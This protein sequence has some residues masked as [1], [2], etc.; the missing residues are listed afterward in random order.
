MDNS[1][2]IL[3][4]SSSEKRNFIVQTQNK[5]Y[6]RVLAMDRQKPYYFKVMM[7]RMNVQY[8]DYLHVRERSVLSGRKY[9]DVA[10]REKGNER[11]V[12]KE[13]LGVVF[14][15]TEFELMV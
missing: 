2:T 14:N 4:L 13:G 6:V 8:L 1:S 12:W 7:Y 9:V 15:H 10:C 5:V 3:N 11:K